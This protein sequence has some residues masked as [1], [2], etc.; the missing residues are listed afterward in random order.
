MSLSV[1]L[2]TLLAMIGV[3]GWLGAAVDT[4]RRLFN[5]KEHKGW[6]VFVNDLLFWLS[7]ALFTFYILYVVNNGE[8]R[9]YIFLA[10]LCGYAAYQSLLKTLYL[11]LLERLIELVKGMY[12]LVVT[13][14]YRGIYIPVTA[15][16]GFMVSIL[17]FFLRSAW[18]IIRQLG[19]ILAKML[20]IFSQP[21]LL[22]G[23]FLWNQ[24]P[25]SF[26]ININKFFHGT[27]L[28]FKRVWRKWFLKN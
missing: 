2:S 9:V 7:Q 11:P 13:I 18:T 28:F 12:R 22:L 27:V 6:Y 21:F 16:I 20:Y 24:C 3:G 14:L 25:D 23:K 4:Y 10:L 19:R 1:Q 26:K 5:R 17:L 15:I 8:L